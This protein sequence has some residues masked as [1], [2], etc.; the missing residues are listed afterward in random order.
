MQNL[1]GCCS[2]A[3]AEGGATEPGF[4]LSELDITFT[5]DEKENTPAVDDVVPNT[6]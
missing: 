4:A 5:P 6:D 3:E 2:S 1:A